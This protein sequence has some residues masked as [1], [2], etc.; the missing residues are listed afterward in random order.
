MS[1]KD[2]LENLGYKL[3]DHGS[4]WRTNALYRSGDNSTA[5]QIYKDSGVWKD[6]VEDSMFLPFEVLVQKTTK[7]SNVK[8]ILKDLKT[9]SL[10]VKTEKNLLKEEKT[11]DPICLKRLLPH[12]DF[13]LNKNISKQTLLDFKCGLAHSGP[14]Y[15]RMVFPI[16]RDDKRIHG[17]S[18]RKIT[19]DDR[20][21]W[22]HKGKTANWFYPYFTIDEVEEQ[23]NLK[24]QVHIVESIGDCMAL[25]NCGIKNVLVSFGLNMSPKFIA[26]LAALN[27]QNIYISYNNDSDS[28][29]NRGFEGAVKSIF[30]LSDA[31]DFDRIYFCPPD[32][33]D[34]GDMTKEQIYFYEDRC[35]S[36][37]H[38]TSMHKVISIAEEM[39][40]KGIN[41]SFSQSL[42]KLKKKYKFYYGRL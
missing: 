38:Q 24:K 41:K 13:Y 39:D 29:R 35:F 14:M 16:F 12:Y 19:N 28:E 40:K 27:L 2:I 36:A 11:Y 15:Q 4:Y 34:F 10:S 7:T 32:S 33:N 37:D 5:L 31:V 42:K 25:Y 22:L 30:K 20:P 9:T 26:R 8:S 1:Y 18:G 6:Y 21:K 3:S 17:F 23:I